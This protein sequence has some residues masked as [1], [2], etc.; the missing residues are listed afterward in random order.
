MQIRE[1]RFDEHGQALEIIR[2][3]FVEYE[4]LLDPPSSVGWE[5][6]ET[7][8][9]RMGDGGVLVLES[10]QALIGCV[11]YE[12]RGNDTLYLG[13]LSVLPAYRGQGLA[14][15]LVAAVEAIAQAEGRQIIQIGVRLALPNLIAMYQQ[16]GY[17]ITDYHSHQGYTEPTYVTMQHQLP[18][19]TA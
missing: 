17:T 8:R 4:T 5:T 11:L 9:A 7:F 12:R 18:P 3:A 13:R 1:A 19:T 10:N 15:Q 16:L 14:K 6:V 2:Q